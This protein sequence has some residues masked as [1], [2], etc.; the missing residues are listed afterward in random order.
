MEWDDEKENENVL[1]LAS[2]PPSAL[3]GPLDELELG[4]LFD[5]HAPALLRAAMRVTGSESDAEDAVQTVFLRL[6]RREESLDLAHPGVGAYLHRATVN[7]AL[8]VVRQRRRAR[9]D[10]A[11]DADAEPHHE[12]GPARQL[13]GRELA[14][15]LRDAIADLSARGAEIFT[16]RYF[17]ELSNQE[18]AERLGTS[19]GTVAVTLHRTRH[20]LKGALAHL[21]GEA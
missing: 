2:N 1:A 10:S 9:I 11:A 7:A 4:G 17:D 13:A 19:P 20:Q 16:L 5:L 21:L 3:P 15:A 12:A 14:D 18:I 6:I 8:D